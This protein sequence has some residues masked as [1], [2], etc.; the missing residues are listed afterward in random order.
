MPQA[1][2]IAVNHPVVLSANRVQTK[3]KPPELLI[4][5]AFE[6]AMI[7]AAPNQIQPN[8]FAAPVYCNVR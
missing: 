6:C 2:R 4:T 8:D 5:P 1:D 7:M 3:K